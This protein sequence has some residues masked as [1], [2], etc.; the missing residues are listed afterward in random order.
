MATL[1]QLL[2]AGVAIGSVY[3]LVAL[4]FVLIYRATNVVNFAQ[5]DF[6]MLG[7]YLL[8]FALTVLHLPYWVAIVA[9]LVTMGGLG[10]LFELGVYYPLRN[11]SFMPVIVST[12]G[13]S[14]VLEN[15]VLAV[16][17]PSPSV[18][19]RLF[20][21]ASIQWRGIFVDG[22]YLLVII[23]T[24]VLVAVQYWFF[25]HTV[26]GKKM[27]AVSQDK[28]TALLIGVPVAAVIALTF[29]YST[30]LGALAGVLVAPILYVSQGLGTNIALKAFA[31]SIIGGFGDVTGAIVGGLLVGLIETFG[32]AY[33]SLPY[34]DAFSLLLLILIL[35]VRPQGIFGE[36]VEQKA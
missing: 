25:E 7:A 23:V 35:I 3:A 17:G 16:F 21:S 14:I 26:L 8:L 36:R 32:G 11:R 24:V 18:L 13:A 34:K 20:G 31:S 4:G 28:E 12:I 33:I 27:Q 1:A 15:G 19:P 22:Q 2:V 9:T 6:A 29:A 30:I 10:V 5:G